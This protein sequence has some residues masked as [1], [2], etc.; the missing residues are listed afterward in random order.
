LFKI[1]TAYKEAR[2]GGNF[3]GLRTRRTD[4][5]TGCGRCL[6]RAM[7]CCV[8]T[9]FHVVLLFVVT[10]LLWALIIV[11]VLLSILTACFL[12]LFFAAHQSCLQMTAAMADALDSDTV[13]NVQALADTV[14]QQEEQARQLAGLFGSVDSVAGSTGFGDGIEEFLLV[15]SLTTYDKSLS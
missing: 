2:K 6:V 12:V 13:D 10:P 1:I 8:H 5:S 11:E 14:K 4:K 3:C 15:L 9:G 7:A